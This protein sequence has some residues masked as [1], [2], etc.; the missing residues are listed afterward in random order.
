MDHQVA[1]ATDLTHLVIADLEARHRQRLIA[2]EIVVAGCVSMPRSNSGFTVWVLP[3][4][5]GLELAALGH[6]SRR[7]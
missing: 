6:Q 2:R 5:N 3:N 1:R 7:P 4:G